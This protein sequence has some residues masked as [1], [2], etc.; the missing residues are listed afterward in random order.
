MQVAVVLVVT[1]VACTRAEPSPP[2][3]PPPKP[4]PVPVPAGHC[5]TH[6]H[7]L[8]K[9]REDVAWTKRV[10]DEMTKGITRKRLACMFGT[11]TKPNG[12]FVEL[13]PR[14]PAFSFALAGATVDH[15]EEAIEVRFAAGFRPLV[16]SIERL[17]GASTESFRHHYD[18]PRRRGIYLP[19]P[20][21]VSVRALLTLDSDDDSRVDTLRLDV[22][23]LRG[24]DPPQIRCWD[25]ARLRISA[26]VDRL[27]QGAW[28]FEVSAAARMIV[29]FECSVPRDMLDIG[30]CTPRGDK[31]PGAVMGPAATSIEL[32]IPGRPRAVELVVTRDGVSITRQ[33]VELKYST[34]PAQT[35]S[36][37]CTTASEWIR[38]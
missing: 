33:Q 10:T 2:A 26:G 15:P 11:P 16:T 9:G 14:S 19:A 30:T 7:V 36:G 31:P 38:L 17:L 27:P 32:N 23:D 25:G 35:P 22:S 37:T 29:K 28:T 20:E 24:W 18:A 21:G 34:A 13:T 12:H 1:C 5:A 6:E 8:P 3:P 4:A